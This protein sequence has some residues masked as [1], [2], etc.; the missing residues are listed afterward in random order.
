MGNCLL[1]YPSLNT[2]LTLTS[3]LG[4]RGVGG[5]WVPSFDTSVRKTPPWT[6]YPESWSLLLIGYLLWL[7]IMQ[8]PACRQP[9]LAVVSM[10]ESVDYIFFF[11]FSINSEGSEDEMKMMWTAETQYM[12]V[13]I[14]IFKQ[15]Q[16]NPRNVSR[17][18]A[19]LLQSSTN[20]AINT[21]VEDLIIS[22]VLCLILNNKKAPSPSQGSAECKC[23]LLVLVVVDINSKTL[24]WNSSSCALCFILAKSQETSRWPS[25]KRWPQ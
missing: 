23:N 15:L 7:A 14:A 17:A 11:L 1:T 4:G 24:N 20:W 5:R 19:P 2:A 18:S 13:V 25:H 12:T 9:L 22:K 16:I 21:H 6:R 3:H 8:T 10:R